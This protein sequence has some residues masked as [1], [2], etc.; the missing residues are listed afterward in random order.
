MRRL[1]L[2]GFLIATAACHRGPGSAAQNDSSPAPPKPN[3]ALE[4]QT[5]RRSDSIWADAIA[6][7]DTAVTAS[8][9]AET[10]VFLP[11]NTARVEGRQ[12]IRNV[13]AGDLNL[14]GFALTFTP[15]RITISPDA[16]MAYDIGTYSSSVTGPNERPVKDQGKYL[17]VWQKQAGEWRVVAEMFNTSLPAH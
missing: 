9:Y 7:H 16:E 3:L 15:S 13:W 17:V 10:A 14:P 12:N 6:R 5:I 4:E 2:A 11:P 8:M 1:V